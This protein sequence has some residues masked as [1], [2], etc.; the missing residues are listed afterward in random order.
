MR[1]FLSFPWLHE[2]L[3]EW[4]YEGLHEGPHPACRSFSADPGAMPASIVL[5]VMALA[6]L[7]GTS[8][9]AQTFEPYTFEAEVTIPVEAERGEIMVPENRTD[10]NSRS[11]P[12]GFVRLASRA[13]TPKAPI[14]YL[15]GGPGGS[16]TRAMRGTR[17]RMFDRL[18]DVADVIILDQRGTGF[19][20]R[21]PRCRSSVQVPADSATTRERYVRLHRKALAECVDVWEAKGVD[22]RGYTTWESAADINAVR[23]ALGVDR[24]SLLGISYGSHLALA[25]LKRY[26]NRIDR[27]VLASPEGLDDTVKRPSRTDA[28]IERLQAAID[29]D[30]VSRSFYPDVR[31]LLKGVLDDVEANPPH[32]LVDD[33]PE[34]RRTLGRF[35]LMRITGYSLS[36]PRGANSILEGY[37]DAAHGDYTWFQ[38]YFD[39]V[40]RDNTI[41][42]NGMAV[43]MDLASGI[44]PKRKAQVSAE[45]ETALLGDAINFP[46]PHLQDALPD[47]DLGSAF[48]EPVSSDRPALL[49]TGTLDGR[50]YPEAHAEIAEGLSNGARVTIRN[51]GHNLFLSHPDVV[52][53]IADFFGGAAPKPRTLTA[54]LPRFAP[55]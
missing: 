41:A 8:A 5:F 52:P 22:L 13:A 45:A 12:I 16:G 35:E 4:L 31:G 28:Y 9:R 37:L 48:R 46:M 2:W 24:V 40:V 34:F 23:K 1:T 21:V 6:S 3:H 17:W 55:D 38:N 42:F 50:T 19:S 32:L 15:A 54:P 43:A 30:S 7:A 26:P 49:L 14:V 53:L 11:I 25:T 44:S 39:W 18:R 27:L 51:A 10:A 47:L 29:A 33:D 20:D 36:D